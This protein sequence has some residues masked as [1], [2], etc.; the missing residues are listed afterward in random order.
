MH[1]TILTRQRRKSLDDRTLHEKR[2]G[3]GWQAIRLVIEKNRVALVVEKLEVGRRSYRAVLA[4]RESRTIRQAGDLK[5]RRLGI[6]GEARL[7]HE[8]LW[9]LRSVEVLL[10]SFFGCVSLP[11]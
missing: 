5:M 3:G 7:L 6:R 10:I 2:P 11:S 4:C 8:R 1:A 9:I